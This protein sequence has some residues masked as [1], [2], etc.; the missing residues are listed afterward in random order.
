MACENTLASVWPDD[1]YF[2]VPLSGSPYINDGGQ[3]IALPASFLGWK[4]RV[5][6]NNTPL[7]YND[8]GTGSPYFTQD[9]N[10]NFITLSNDALEDDKFMIQAYKPV[11]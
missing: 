3:V 8:Q 5:N 2:R 9:W 7:D 11:T 6:R 1:L 4:V 10:N